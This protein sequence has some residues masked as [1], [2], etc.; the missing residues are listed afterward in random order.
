[1]TKGKVTKK[2]AQEFCQKLGLTKLRKINGEW[3]ATDD[4]GNPDYVIDAHTYRAAK[5]EGDLD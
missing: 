4:G 1:M 2:Q 5:A 3:V